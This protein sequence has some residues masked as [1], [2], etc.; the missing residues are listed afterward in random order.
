MAAVTEGDQKQRSNYR[1]FAARSRTRFTHAPTASPALAA[2]SLYERLRASE[3]RISSLSCSA[4]SFGGLPLFGAFMM[5]ILCPYK[6]LDKGLGHLYS[7]RTVTHDIGETDMEAL[8]NEIAKALN[9]S[10]EH[11]GEMKVVGDALWITTTAGASYTAD[12]VRNATKL[13][14]NSVRV[15]RY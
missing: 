5:A 11:I 10:P 9:L 12:T 8:K 15:A 6:V 7:V 3:R 1:R 2:A 4:S 13:K 14:A